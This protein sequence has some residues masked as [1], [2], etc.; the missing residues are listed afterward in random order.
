MFLDLLIITLVIVFVQNHSGFTYSL[1][2]FVYEKAN[3]K[4]YMGQSMRKI[5]SCSLCEV[6][7][8]TLI[9]CLIAGLPIIQSFGMATLFAMFSLLVDKLV[10]VYIKLVNKI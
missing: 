5:F 3:K 4:K 1:G 8:I 6:H 2:K 10:G 7:W 9:Y